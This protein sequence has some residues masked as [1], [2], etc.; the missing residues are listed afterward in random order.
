QWSPPPR[1][2]IRV[3]SAPVFLRG[4]MEFVVPRTRELD[5]PRVS[6]KDGALSY[7]SVY[8][9]PS[10]VIDGTDEL[11]KSLS[12]LRYLPPLVGL[13]F[14]EI[15]IYWLTSC[16]LFS[17]RSLAV[18]GIF[19]WWLVIPLAYKYYLLLRI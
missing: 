2:T 5:I 15:L 1:F 11:G 17:T 13:V 6:V 14:L 9:S 3:H 19:F 8:D 7:R 18:F 10:Q 16:L 12:K 4:L